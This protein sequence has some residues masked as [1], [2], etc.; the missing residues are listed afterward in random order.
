MNVQQDEDEDELRQELE[1]LKGKDE[2][3]H[4][5]EV[6]EWAC[7]HKQSA[8]HREFEWDDS[9]AARQYRLSQARRLIALHIIDAGGERKAISLSIDRATGGGYRMVNDVLR[10]KNLRQIMLTD[11]LAELRRVRQKYQKLSELAAV[12]EAIDAADKRHGKKAA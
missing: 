10:R 6:V 2:K 3:I 4:A 11:A 12:F 8:L 1:A 7:K 9:E 5:E